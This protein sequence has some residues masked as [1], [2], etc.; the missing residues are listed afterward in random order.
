MSMEPATQG[1]IHDK[2]PSRLTDK[3]TSIRFSSISTTAIRWTDAGSTIV[4]NK[5]LGARDG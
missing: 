2:W 5:S 4:M 1:W 3:N